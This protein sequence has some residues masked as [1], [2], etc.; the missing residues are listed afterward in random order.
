LPESGDALVLREN[1]GINPGSHV[2]IFSGY[3]SIENLLIFRPAN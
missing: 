1:F 3:E 2:G